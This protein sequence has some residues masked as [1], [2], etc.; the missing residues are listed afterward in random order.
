MLTKLK[1]FNLCVL[2]PYVC[3]Y[4]DQKDLWNRYATWFQRVAKKTLKAGYS[5]TDVPIFVGYIYLRLLFINLVK[6]TIIECFYETGHIDRE[7]ILQLWM[8][9]LSPIDQE[10]FPKIVHGI[11]LHFVYKLHSFPL[12]QNQ[13][14]SLAEF[15]CCTLSLIK[16]FRHFH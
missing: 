9:F 15:N 7:Q 6:W 8:E 13:V 11:K 16:C 4:F 14:R 10:H 2:C 5:T 3:E 12:P 1:I